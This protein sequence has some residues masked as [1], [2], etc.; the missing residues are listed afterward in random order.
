MQMYIAEREMEMA[1]N[2]FNH[3]EVLI[4]SDLKRFN[5]ARCALDN[6]GINYSIKTRNL[7]SPSYLPDNSR[8]RGIPGTKN[9]HAYEY[10]IFVHKNDYEQA[11]YVIRELLK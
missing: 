1:I 6:A 3:R 5:E 7:F 4:T 8:T 2:M 11:V 10:K 9:E